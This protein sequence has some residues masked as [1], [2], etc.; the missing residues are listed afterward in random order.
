M[1]AREIFF[2]FDT[3]VKVNKKTLLE[4][5][6]EYDYYIRE[7]FQYIK[8]VFNVDTINQEFLKE[9][10]R[11]LKMFD[12]VNV[13]S[14]QGTPKFDMIF[15]FIQ[16]TIIEEPKE[17]DGLLGVRYL[18]DEW[19]YEGCGRDDH[20]YYTFTDDVKLIKKTIKEAQKLIEK[21]N[22]LGVKTKLEIDYEKT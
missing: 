17:G 21:L 6:K 9:F 11:G 22:E 19:E 14:I 5:I 4:F 20:Y 15:K 13:D 7:N 10:I 3:K 18:Y 2:T 12:S 1:P 8:E 16:D